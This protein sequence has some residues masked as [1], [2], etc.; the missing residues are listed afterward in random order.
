MDNPKPNPTPSPA[1]D[2]WEATANLA[3]ALAQSEPVLRCKAAEKALNSDRH[4][5]ELLVDLSDLQQ[6]MRTQ[7][8]SNPVSRDDVTRLRAL[9]SEVGGDQTIQDYLL[10]Q[11]LAVVM[12]R[13]VNLEVSNLLGV[14]FASLARRS[15]CC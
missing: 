4:A 13:D 7:P 15:G 10:A 2:L 1:A 3:G 9:Q 11:E 6:K 14:D 8:V 5:A 12:L